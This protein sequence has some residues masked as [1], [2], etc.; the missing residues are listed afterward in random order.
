VLLDD[1][2]ERLGSKFQDADLIGSPI[3]IVF[4]KD[5]AE[6]YVEIHH[7]VMNQ[8]ERVLSERH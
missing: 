1:R 3:V 8:K 2:S 4:G 7:R 6:G 5:V